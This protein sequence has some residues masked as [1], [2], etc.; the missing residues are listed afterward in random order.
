MCFDFGAPIGF[1]HALAHP[2]RIM[3]LFRKNGNAYEEGLGASFWKPVRAAWKESER[4]ESRLV[5]FKDRF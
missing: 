5:A 2:E 4:C 1:R 3:A